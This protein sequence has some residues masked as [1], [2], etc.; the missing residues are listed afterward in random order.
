MGTDASCFGGTG[1]I[2]VTASGGTGAYQ[3]SLDGG[4]F[5]ASGTFLNVAVG[6]HN[7]VARDINLCLSPAAP[8]TISAPAAVAANPV[9]TDAS[10]FGGTGSITVTASGGTG[11]YQFSLDGGVFQAS[12]TFLNV[13]V[14]AH[15]VVARDVNLC[16]S[17]A[18]PVTIS[19]PAAVAANP[20]G[21]DASC[22]GGTGSITV[23]ASG[24]TG[25]YQFSLD[26]GVFQASGTFLNVAVGAH[27]VVARDINLCLSP[28]APVT[29]S[30]P[31]AVAASP[32]GTDASCFG[33]TGSITV[34]ASGGTGAYQ[35]SLDGGVFQASGTFLNVAVGAHNVVARD[36]NLCLSPAAPVTIS[37]PAAVAA[38]PVGTDA[39][40]FGGTGSI[41]VTAS[42]GTG[43]YQFSLDGGVFQ[44]SGTFPN[45]G[46][47][48]AQRRGARYQSVPEPG[49]AR[50]D[51]RPAAVAA[52]PVGTDASCFGGTG[53]ITVTASGGTGAYQFSLDGGVFQASGTFLNVAVGAHNVVAR[54]IN[55]CLSP[56][57]PVTIS[58]P[59]AVAA[60]PVG[61]DA[62]CFG[63]TGSITVTASGGTGAYQFSLDG[64]VFQASGS[65]LNV[66]VG[67]HN[68]VARDINL[69]LSPAAPVTISAPAAVAANPV[70]TDA[71]CFGGTGSITVTASGGTGAYQFS[72]DGGVFQASGTFLN[73]AVGAHNVVARD[74]NLCL[75]PAA[76]VTISA[77]AAV[78]ANPVGTD[79]SCFGGTG[80]ITVTASGGTGAY[81]FSLDGGVFQ[82]SGTFL[83]V[84]VGA[85]NVVA[86]D[87]NLCLS[88]AAPV[89]IS[90]PAAVAANPVGTD[91]SCFGGTGS[92]T[93]T[94][95]G[96]TGAYQFSLDGGVFQASGTFLNVAVGAHN[97]VARDINLCLSPAAPVTIS[98]PAAVA[99]NPVGTDASC[100]GGTGSITVT[101]SG[102]TG[103]YQFS[104]DGGVFQ[105]SGTFLNVAVGAHNV[106]ARDINL[107]LSPAAPVTISAP[108]AVAANPVGTDASCFGG[109]GSITV[110]AWAAPARINSRWMA[111][112][113]RPARH[114]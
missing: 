52:N 93:V 64:G 55:L 47:G 84:A 100:F 38:N 69:C 65:F 94:A 48:R 31:A 102:G 20:V 77:P 44:V 16:L 113:S 2:T 79:A 78:A 88:P 56:A 101:A 25:A 92:I 45:G 87:I 60:N 29:I 112:S 98:A 32:V 63:G 70:G 17:P 49:S 9:G 81:Q 7:V 105:A 4:V 30:A 58:A 111:A 10:C 34:T 59:A 22:F 76:P 24:G 114:S 75:S 74:I 106:V 41:T 5:Q 19:A 40:C 85:H 67:A 1:S 66:A 11:A 27:N 73:V 36:I 8:V 86:R 54:D 68:V 104:L 28:A 62:S 18:A 71:S 53:S 82:A 23:T 91:A 39:S 42:G 51:Q 83:N 89:T 95:S 109:T 15:N 61:T 110:T 14:G 3:F 26:G 97:V 107:C 103:A 90:A 35:F 108:A 37:A 6:A 12:G 13:A 50:D 33:G 96:G 43:A 80:S 21:T 46:G 72:L 99:A 57:A